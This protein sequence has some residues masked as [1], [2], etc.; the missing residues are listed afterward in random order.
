MRFD[1]GIYQKQKDFINSTGKA[2]EVLYGGA[3]G[4]GKSYGQLIDA[5]IYATRYPKSRQLILRRTL[6]ELEKS[7]IR[8]SLE[9]FP[10]KIYKYSESKHTGTFSNGSVI[11]FG[12]CDSESD[13]YRYQSAEYDVIRF[14]E[15]THFT[16]QMYLYLMSRLR[17]VT[18]YP[19]A[20]KSSTNPGGIGHSW[21]KKR[22]IDIGPPGK[23]HSTKNGKRLFI[24]STVFENRA[25]MKN[26]P[27]YVRRLLELSEK[28]RKQLLEGDWDTNE[29]QYFSEWK[30][31]TH[32]MRPF[33]IPKR[34]RRYFAMDYGLD[35]LAGYWIAVDDFENAYVYREIYKSGLIISEAAKQIIEAQGDDVPDIYIAPPDMWNR[36]Q[37]TGKSVAELFYE[38]GILLFKASNDR[39]QGWYCLKEWLHPRKD[40]FGEIKPKLRIF[41][42]CTEVIRTLPA[43]VFDRKN[44]NDVGD[45]VHEYTHA[46]DA[47]RYWA[48]A[49]P[50]STE[51]KD[52]EEEIFFENEMEEFIRFGTG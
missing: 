45:S 20:M 7:L 43:L 5:L 46:A 31:E 16:E 18:D 41:E 12:Y 47:L 24:P 32:V 10:A 14:D 25:L 39:V 8:V 49:R 23:I 19:R 34:W 50:M 6:P 27:E 11:D 44:P 37:D 30:R 42:N 13:V 51:Q 9:I 48:A 33:D 52:F 26:D 40:E 1:I 4:G 28:D 15:L 36:R 17:G 2:N 21:V 38:Q 35:M 22:F 3:A 29:G